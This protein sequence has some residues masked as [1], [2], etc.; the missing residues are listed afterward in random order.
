MAKVDAK[1]QN[2][3]F[4][5]P[6]QATLDRLKIF[7]PLTDAEQTSFETAFQAAAGNA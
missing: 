3:E 4:I 1:L 6:T 5:F 7:R 2:S